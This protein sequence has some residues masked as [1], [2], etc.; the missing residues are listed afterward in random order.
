MHPGHALWGEARATPLASGRVDSPLALLLQTG[1]SQSPDRAAAYVILVREETSEVAVTSQAVAVASAARTSS[2]EPIAFA[3]AI[4]VGFQAVL[5]VVG[6]AG[7][8]SIGALVAG[9]VT[10]F[11]ADLIIPARTADIATA[12]RSGLV[13][14]GD[15][16][17]A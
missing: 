2:A 10:V 7:A 5:F 11:C 3:A 13:T 12:V 1:Q 8:P 14:V 16:V 6:A 17:G 4:D 15:A 9:T